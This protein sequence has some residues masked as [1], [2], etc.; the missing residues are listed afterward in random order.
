MEKLKDHWVLSFVGLVSA[1]VGMY[2]VLHNLA[3]D[4]VDRPTAGKYLHGWFD[5]ATGDDP[6]K[7]YDAVDHPTGT[8]AQFIAAFSKIDHVNLSDV[9]SD[10]K[11][12][13][14]AVVTYCWKNGT[15]WTRDQTFTLACSKWSELPLVDCGDIRIRDFT[16][17]Q[18]YPGGIC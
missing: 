10:P 4:E 13:F 15:I 3:P 18:K 12:G 14:T 1:L 6:S 7:A 17:E 16:T 11:G 5:A 2:P 9:R 8:R